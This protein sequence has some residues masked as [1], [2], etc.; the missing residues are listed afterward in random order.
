MMPDQKGLRIKLTKPSRKQIL[1]RNFISVIECEK[2]SSYRNARLRGASAPVRKVAA[3][4]LRTLILHT[5]R[6]GRW[7]NPTRASRSPF[8]GAASK[9]PYRLSF[10]ASLAPSRA[11]QMP[12]DVLIYNG[13]CALQE[14]GLAL[15]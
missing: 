6:V 1:W 3:R 14:N 7:S 5:V 11:I 2:I 8:A 9:W 4:E 13:H 15:G 10:P 12:G